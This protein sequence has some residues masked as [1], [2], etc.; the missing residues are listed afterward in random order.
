[1]R[2]DPD[3]RFHL[4][5]VVWLAI[6]ALLLVRLPLLLHRKFDPDEFEHAHA[7]WCLFKG[8]LPYRDFFEH[9]TPWYYYTLRP[10]FHLFAVDASFESA[11]HLLLVGRALSLLLT[12]L[13]VSLTVRLGRHWEDRR[14]GAVGAL[15]LV[16]QPLFLNKTLEI[17]PD[18]LALPFFLAGLAVLVRALSRSGD[19]PR[20]LLAA[21]VTGGLCV[22]AANMCTQK[23]LFVLPG[24]LAGLGLWALSPGR[25]AARVGLIAAFLVGVALPGIVTW[26]AF[27]LQH[28]GGAFVA[29]NFLLNAHWKRVTSRQLMK[30]IKT[31]APVLGLAALGIG[32]AVRRWFQ[33]G[34]RDD[35]EILIAC[36]T[37]GLFAGVLV[38]P[39]A[40]AQYYLM[41][42]PLAALFAARGLFR[43]LDAL[44]VRNALLALATAGL[45]ILPGIALWHSFTSA[46]DA[47]LARLGEVFERTQPTDLVMDGWEGTGVFRPHA[48][49]YYFVHEELL[50][51]L[52]RARVD[53][54]LDDLES[55]RIR[56]KL[57]ALDPYLVALDPRLL[58]L[59]A[60]DYVT[61][62]GFLYY[63]ARG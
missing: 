54:Y 63:R 55:G 15:L 61:R 16:S 27:A 43:L 1:M 62:D 44:P 37:L 14:V 18:V 4:V 38:I 25:V 3:Q 2:R 33:S 41:P 46:N 26:G 53:A 57:I 58:R 50:P 59:V 42:L 10:L 9:H 11:R 29:N 24:L 32:D 51:M 60:R 49:Y 22:G 47:Q 52:D 7:A 40:Q 21:F 34:R 45:S 19:P 5:H 35:G 17:R 36:T 23:I 30:L 8:M 20:R 12:V 56:P 39:V 48:F 31:S 13:S 6:A 28:G